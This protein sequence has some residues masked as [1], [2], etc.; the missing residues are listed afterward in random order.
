MGGIGTS[1]NPP[2]DQEYLYSDGFDCPADDVFNDTR[3]R[4][5]GRLD[6]FFVYHRRETTI[7]VLITRR[8]LD[9]CGPRVFGTRTRRVERRVYGSF[10]Y[11]RRNDVP[12]LRTERVPSYHRNDFWDTK[13]VKPTPRTLEVAVPT[14][15]ETPGRTGYGSKMSIPL[16]L[17]FRGWGVSPD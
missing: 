17:G 14:F 3:L 7:H 11:A 6:V 9:F 1:L 10:A 4:L 15:L 5:D 2:G 16:V 8:I 12:S 13:S